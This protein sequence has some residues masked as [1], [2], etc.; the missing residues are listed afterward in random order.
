MPYWGLCGSL[1]T[2]LEFRAQAAE[3]YRSTGSDVAN[4]DL[5]LFCALFLRDQKDERAGQLATVHVLT[6]DRNL[7]I[8]AQSEELSALSFEDA[9]CSVQQACQLHMLSPHACMYSSPGKALL[10]QDQIIS[11]EVHFGSDCLH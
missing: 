11:P 3:A 10:H 4:D 1:D 5:V 7:R 2:P 9:P 6:D 8:K